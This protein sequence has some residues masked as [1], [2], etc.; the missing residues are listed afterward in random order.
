M[1]LMIIFLCF[2]LA[3]SYTSGESSN[4]VNNFSLRLLTSAKDANIFTPDEPVIL[5]VFVRNLTPDDKQAELRYTIVDYYGKKLC[6]GLKNISISAN[7]EIEIGIAVAAAGEL[8]QEEYLEANAEIWYSED[9]LIKKTVGIGVLPIRKPKDSG[10]TSCFG[11][12]DGGGGGYSWYQRI[13]ARW[14]RPGVN[15]ELS[16][17]FSA[18]KYGVN[19]AFMFPIPLD[20][21]GSE[22]DEKALNEFSNFIYRTVSKFKDM[23]K[24]WQIGNE[25]DY[26]SAGSAETLIKV[27]EAGYKSARKAD[28]NCKIVMAGLTGEES[29]GRQGGFA[30]LVK[31]GA[32]NY[33]DIY[34]HH[35]YMSFPQIRELLK[36]TKADMEKHKA[37]KP[38]WVTET[39]S[40]FALPPDAPDAD[41]AAW[42]I[43]FYTTALSYGVKKIYWFA[44][45]WPFD[46]DPRWQGLLRPD[47][48]P[49]LKLFTYAAMTRELE[50]A[51]FSR[52]IDVSKPELYAYEFTHGDYSN[53]VI[54]SDGNDYKL[55]LRVPNGEVVVTEISG[56]R[57]AFSVQKG[58]FSLTATVHPVIL[59]LPGKVKLLNVEK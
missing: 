34:D 50:G 4:E 27:L 11:L 56:R 23:V 32:G 47:R 42:M 37:V 51:V 8:P 40:Y 28:P 39:S 6:N 41:R 18:R 31:L 48:T 10:E 45:Y 35:L 7:Q 53:L 59:K 25:P 38:V 54:W 21:M 19:L 20:C 29:P 46:N 24:Y 44:V 57:T 58:V 17:P 33:C 22:I 14:D 12:V 3:I 36:R 15:W 49:T 52:Q 43:K 1:R 30:N 13:G 55:N 2:L 16:G 26:W 9:L 5:K